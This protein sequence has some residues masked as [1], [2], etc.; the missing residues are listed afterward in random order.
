MRPV[1]RGLAPR[2]F[3]SYQ[4]AKG[5]LIGRMGQY[6][7]YCEM[8]LG[9]SL[10]VEH[11]QPKDLNP[12]LRNVWN[13]FLLACTN[14]NSTKGVTAVVLTDYFWPDSDNTAR[15]LT[16]S[17]GGVVSVGTGLNTAQQGI[18]QNTIGLTGLDCRPPIGGKASDW[19]WENRRTAWDKANR[20][21]ENLLKADSFHM[22]EQIVD[23]AISKGFFSVW[24]TV[25]QSDADMLN[26][27]IA[28][29]PGTAET[30]FDPTTG[31]C[32]TVARGQI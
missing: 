14:C 13:N 26:R 10:A 9:A 18:A 20:A 7:S 24:M 25:F 31:Q 17:Q 27:F 8:P 16:Y 22:R 19:R 3:T 12:G 1:N 11:V 4:Q 15:V 5:P 6:C 32:V 2:T 29:F 21:L 23:T 28:A 30:C